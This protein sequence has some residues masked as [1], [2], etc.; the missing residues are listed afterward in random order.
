[1]AS[2]ALSLVEIARALADDDAELDLPVE[3]GRLA[4]NDG[5]VVW[6]ADAGRRLVEDDRFFRDRHA[7]FLGVVA[8]VEPDGDEVAHMADARPEPR[9]AGDGLH[10][11]EVRLLDLGE[12]AGGE[13]LAVDVFDDARE[14]ADLAV[15][16][17][18]AGLLAAGRAIADELH[19]GLPGGVCSG[20]ALLDAHD[21]I[22]KPVPTFR[23]HARAAGQRRSC[24]SAG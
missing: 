6:P 16:S 19:E 20:L 17:D 1:M 23:D 21:L 5:V 11:F 10:A 3:L 15:L 9:L 22:R 14:V 12:A 4:R 7:G 2:F 8:V 18:D 13:H 24:D